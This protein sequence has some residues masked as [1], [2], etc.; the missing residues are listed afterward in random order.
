MTSIPRLISLGQASRL[1]QTKGIM[2]PEEANPIYRYD[3]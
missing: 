3:A 1:T 2:F